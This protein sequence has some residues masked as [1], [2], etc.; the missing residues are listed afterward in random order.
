MQVSVIVSCHK[1][2]DCQKGCQCGFREIVTGFFMTSN[3]IF[4]FHQS[5]AD[6]AQRLIGIELSVTGIEL[7]EE[8]KNGNMDYGDRFV[9]CCICP[10][11]VIN[12]QEEDNPLVPVLVEKLIRILNSIFVH[13]IL[14]TVL[15]LISS[16]C[17]QTTI[18]LSRFRYPN[19]F[20]FIIS[21]QSLEDVFLFSVFNDIVSNWSIL[22]KNKFL[23][24]TLIS[25]FSIIIQSDSVSDDPEIETDTYFYLC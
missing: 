16:N 18:K 2:I 17:C 11:T 3:A 21:P 25:I 9:V 7:L 24:I 5:D 22:A 10:R 15:I 14:D 19:E 4:S 12:V 8:L 23:L 6:Y 1:L 20:N 13:Y